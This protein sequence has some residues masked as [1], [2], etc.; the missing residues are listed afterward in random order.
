M[1]VHFA[2]RNPNSFTDIKYVLELDCQDV[3]YSSGVR[4]LVLSLEQ[5][6]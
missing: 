6:G 3:C 4:Y 1:N 5:S 2:T